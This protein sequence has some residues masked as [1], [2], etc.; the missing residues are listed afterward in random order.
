MDSSIKI[1]R[2]VTSELC[3]ACQHC[4]R[5]EILTLATLDQLELAYHKGHDVLWEPTLQT[6]FL[7]LKNDCQH[8]TKDGCS[9]YRNKR[10]P[11]L[12]RSWACHLP[13]RIQKIHP[14]L[15]QAG[16]RICNQLFG[17][18]ING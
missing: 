6:W 11:K 7:V 13:G 4:C 12:C 14:I 15:V 5:Y 3:I 18:R 2:G 8:I 17:G 9:I 1:K 10:K 16:Q